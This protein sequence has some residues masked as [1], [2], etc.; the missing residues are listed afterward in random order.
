MIEQGDG[1]FAD[2]L[3]LNR[4]P[5]CETALPKR[6]DN[7]LRVERECPT[8]ELKIIEYRDEDRGNG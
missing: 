1:R 7:G 5:K 2:F 8:C 4:C 3:R 6:S